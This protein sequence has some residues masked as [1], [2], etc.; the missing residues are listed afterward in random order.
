MAAV[1]L[2]RISLLLENILVSHFLPAVCA[3][4]C[5]EVGLV[6]PCLEIVNDSDMWGTGR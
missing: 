1:S 3:F 4:F 2:I 6:Q 5:F